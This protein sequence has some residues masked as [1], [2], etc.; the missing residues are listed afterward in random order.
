VIKRQ[1]RK[2]TLRG[3]GDKIEQDVQETFHGFDS[4]TQKRGVGQYSGNAMLD[5]V[6]YIYEH[7]DEFCLLLD[8]SYGTR[9]HTGN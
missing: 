3:I 9:F 8:A 2:F 6:D 4:E 5:M 1:I 7:F